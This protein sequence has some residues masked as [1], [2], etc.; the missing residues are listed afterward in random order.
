MTVVKVK[1]LD[2]GHITGLK[3]FLAP[4]LFSK[5]DPVLTRVSAPQAPPTVK[6]K[7][8]YFQ[9]KNLDGNRRCADRGFK[10]TRILQ[11]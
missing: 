8:D 2:F 5:S 3:K 11:F 4:H 10:E 1:F 6:K 9:R 7:R